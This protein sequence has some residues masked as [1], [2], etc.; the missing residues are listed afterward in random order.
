MGKLKW[1]IGVGAFLVIVGVVAYVGGQSLR[2]HPKDA[3]DA[4]VRACVEA[5]MENVDPGSDLYAPTLSKVT[6][7]CESRLGDS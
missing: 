1:W 6:E 7:A 4:P 5:S 2:S 3:G